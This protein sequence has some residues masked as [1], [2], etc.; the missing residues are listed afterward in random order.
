MNFTPSSIAALIVAASFAAGLNVYA[1]V[2]TLG[3]LAHFHWVVLPGG[4]ESLQNPWIIAVAEPALRQSRSS[5]TRFPPSTCSGTPRTPSSASQSPRC[6]PIRGRIAPLAGDEV[7][8]RQQA[9]PPSPRLRTPPRPPRARW[10]RP[11]RSPSPTSRSQ[12][13]EDVAAISLTWIATHHPYVA[14]GIA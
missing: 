1:T 11:A 14:G 8:R 13:G 9:V 3:L 10:S 12:P 5:P 4:L 2:A 6:W 7:A